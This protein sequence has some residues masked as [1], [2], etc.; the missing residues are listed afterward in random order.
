MAGAA[1]IVDAAPCLAVYLNFLRRCS[2]RISGVF[3][4]ALYKAVA[5]RLVL[6]D[7]MFSSDLDI[8]LAAAHSFIINASLRRTN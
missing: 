6:T 1:F 8:A 7:G 5:A 2:H 3:A 4:A